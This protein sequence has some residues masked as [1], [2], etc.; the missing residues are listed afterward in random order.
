MV[1]DLVPGKGV[2]KLSNHQKMSLSFLMTQSAGTH[3]AAWLNP[4]ANATGG[5]NINYY[6]SLAQTAER[7]CFDLFFVADTPAVRTD[8]LHAW[9]RFPFYT[10]MLEPMT[11]LAAL[12]GAT[13]NIG[14]G[15]TMTTSYSEPYNLARQFASLD[16]I[17]AGRA[18]WNVVT[19]ASDYVARNY[20]HAKLPP[21]A[22]RYERAH[23]FVDLVTTLW[24]SWDDDAF[25]CDRKS[26]LFYE[27]SRQH[28]VHHEG[29]FFKVDGALNIARSPQGRPVIIQAGASDAGFEL[30]ARTAELVFAS[31]T[32][33]QDAKREYD[34]LKGRLGKYGRG[35]AS[36]R[37]LAGLPVVIGQSQQEADDKFQALREMI[38]PDVGRVFLGTDLEAD[39]SDLP[40]DEPIPRERLPK[41]A[42][43]QKMQ[44]A[45]I[46]KMID[47]ENLTLRQLYQRY[48]R[49]RKTVAG[50]PKRIADVMEE[51]FT[52]GAADGFMMQFA[53]LPDGL[54]DFVNLV[55]P[56]LQ[57]RGLFRTAYSGS[58]LRDHLGLTR[59]KNRHAA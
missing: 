19:S 8:N 49:G 32:N 54:T 44:F 22:L 3:P 38:H 41:S 56:E 50:T 16:H 48:E 59:P 34:D 9:S 35:S 4:S 18:A 15:G 33:T 39:L 40:L 58:T 52:M 26:G 55:V 25:I 47:E 37:I 57:R 31:A 28:A 20:G 13:K 17:S 30:A 10:N 23:E 51:W 36:L 29:K 21:H 14:L 12:A 6:Q 24:D 7:G 27:P 46:L 53:T 11:L 1:S 43:F 5:T 42:N 45:S 2:E